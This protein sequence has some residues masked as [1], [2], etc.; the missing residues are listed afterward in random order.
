MKWVEGKGILV[1]EQAGFRKQRSTVDQLYIMYEVIKNRYPKKTYCCF[2]DI[3]KAYDRVW[4]E[5]L[6]MKM[7]KY[8]IR[9]K[10]WRVIKNMYRRVESCVLVNGKTT[11]FFEIEVGVRQGCMISPML[12][13]LLLTG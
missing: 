1:E 9:G 11:N 2:L 5:G 6:W 8:G 3:Q 12:F 13:L 10:M 7:Y 4:R